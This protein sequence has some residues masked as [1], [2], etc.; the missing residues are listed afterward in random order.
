MPLCRPTFELNSKHV[1]KYR[2]S[3][4]IDQ[5][6]VF[7]CRATILTGFIGPT[8]DPTGA[9][10]VGPI[11]SRTRMSKREP[12]VQHVTQQCSLRMRKPDRRRHKRKHAR[13]IS[14]R[15]PSN[16][17]PTKDG[18]LEADICCV[19]GAKSGSRID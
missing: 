14:G 5:T 16:Q 4:K 10:K 7:R 12:T 8:T 17:F 2:N 3:R 18:A 6:A 13:D 9:M 15:L 1:V 19:R 11:I